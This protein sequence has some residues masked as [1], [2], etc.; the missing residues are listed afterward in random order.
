MDFI[1][2]L[3][4]FYQ[5]SDYED[6][7]EGLS[8]FIHDGS[9]ELTEDK[10]VTVQVSQEGFM[11]LCVFTPEQWDMACHISEVS[12]KDIQQ[13][14]QELAEDGDITTVVIDPTEF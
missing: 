9:G 3:L 2:R 4:Q 13:V 6:M 5:E 8:K 10:I 11:V 12:N 7:S 1:K 14:V